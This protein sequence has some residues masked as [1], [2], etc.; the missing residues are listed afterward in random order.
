VFV[1]DSYFSYKLSVTSTVTSYQLQVQLQVISYTL[2]VGLGVGVLIVGSKCRGVTFG[3]EFEMNIFLLL[4]LKSF[5]SRGVL[6]L[7]TVNL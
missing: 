2:S 3:R 4:S 5:A 1:F 6:I 7:L